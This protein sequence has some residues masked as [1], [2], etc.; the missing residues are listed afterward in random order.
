MKELYYKYVL[1]LR[2]NRLDTI[3]E[4]RETSELARLRAKLGQKAKL[5]PR[6]RFYTLYHHISRDD[7]LYEAWKCVKTNGGSAGIDGLTIK[8]IERSS[9]GIMGFLKEIQNELRT[10]T[11]YPKPIKRVFIPKS[12]GTLRPLGIP[13]VK[14]RVVQAAVLQIIGPIF[15]QDFL[16]CSYGFR[17]GKSAHQAIGAIKAA[18]AER[19]L[20]IY[21]ADLKSYFD[22]IPHEKLLKA[23]EMRIADRQV[24]K[25]IRKWLKAPIWE[26]GKPMKANDKGTPQGGIISPLLA[27]LYMHWFDKV[28]HA[29]Q[30]PGN[31]AKATLVRYADDF[32]VMAKYMTPRVIDWI[33]KT[34]EQRFTLTINR[35]K[36]KIVDLGK[37]QNGI[38]FVGYSLKQIPLHRKEKVKFCL[39]APSDKSL[40]KAFEEIRERT[41]PKNGY[42]PIK[43][44]I[45]ELNLFLRGW[46]QYFKHGHPSRAFSKINRHVSYN[47]YKFLQRRS[48]RGY[49]KRDKGTWYEHFKSMGLI[50]LTKEGFRV[51]A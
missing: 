43:Q 7:V 33:E 41:S 44:V 2:A 11:Y 8:A 14:D 15:E 46:G 38:N 32:V 3:T 50:V 20:Q 13:T 4:Q 28:F 35:E 16:P 23:V 31:W 6:F 51:K 39:T 5:E 42:K 26:A 21:D 1:N 47:L 45:V 22:T 49:K 48:Q 19:K 12:D 40:K 36:T 24:L 29:P 18:V 34:L 27:N 9:G 30:G 10:K 25:L 37:P 17:P